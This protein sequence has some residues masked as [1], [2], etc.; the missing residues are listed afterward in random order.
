MSDRIR[1]GRWIWVGL[2]GLALLLAAPG[3][4]L[5]LW[6][7]NVPDDVRRSI[8]EA[9]SNHIGKL[10]DEKNEDGYRFRRASFSKA[11]RL[12][13]DGSYLVSVSEDT[14][15][16]E[17][18]KVERFEFTLNNDGGRWAITEKE[19]VDSWSGLFRSVL[20][21]EEFYEFDSIS[22]SREGLTVKGGK[23]Q[24][25]TD[26]FN[27]ELDSWVLEAENLQYEYQ[28]PAAL[29]A[30]KRAVWHVW[31]SLFQTI[32]DF[33]PERVFVS[34]H[35]DVCP[36][37]W[38]EMLTNPRPIERSQLDSKLENTFQKDHVK[39][40]EDR[41]KDNG[42]TGYR[43]PDRADRE[44]W[45]VS[46]KHK[47]DE[48][49]NFLR[50]NSA[51][52]H[53]VKAGI[54]GAVLFSYFSEA[55]RQ[56]DLS[57]AELERREEGFAKIVDVSSVIGEVEMSVQEVESVQGDLEIKLSVKEDRS[58]I[59]FFLSLSR[60]RGDAERDSRRPALTINKLEDGAGR[61]L[62]W[63]RTGRSGG[64]IILPEPIS[65]G[66]EVT[67]QI[68]Y[69]AQNMIYK[70]NPTYS[71]VPR[72]SWLP[73][74]TPSDLIETYE[75]TLGVPDKYKALGAGTMVSESVVDRKNVS[76]WKN[77]Y[78]LSFPTVIFGDYIHDKPKIKA[79]RADGTE[80][81]VNIYVDKTAASP[82]TSLNP[83]ITE[84]KVRQYRADIAG[85]R[86][87]VRPSQLRPLAEQ[88]VNALNLYGAL[89]GLDYPYGKLDLVNNPVQQGSGGQSPCAMVYLSSDSFRGEGELVAIH[90]GGTRFFKKL[91]AHEVGHQWWGGLFNNL[92]Q[93]NYWFIES[94]AEFS[95]ALWT[96]A[97]NSD[98][99]EK[100]EK[101]Y[102]EYM[103]Q[104]DGWRRTILRA[105]L[106]G[107]I[108]ESDMQAAPVETG[109]ARQALIYNK[110][111]YAF[112]MMRN[113]VGDEAMW[114]LM[115][116]IGQE[117]AGKLIVTSDL[118]RVAEESLGRPMGWF[119]DQWIRG[120]GIPQYKM[121]YE[122]QKAEDGNW[123]VRG[124]VEQRIVV[125]DGPTRSVVEGGKFLALVP[126]TV[127]GRDG[128][129]YTQ[130]VY[131][132]D[133]E[134]T[135][136]FKVPVE[137]VEVE[138]NKHGETLAHDVLVNRDWD[139]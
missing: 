7:D 124:S 81:P 53:E 119:F 52:I 90:G 130:P 91:V 47:G 116:D 39:A 131:V 134:A 136:G 55:T 137:P 5:A 104:V 97:V 102:K 68:A 44:T 62:T 9:L 36:E 41:L 74:I 67:I 73:F 132:R 21:D 79:T 70:L 37:L 19:L 69:D 20:G 32:R 3:L 48:L 18:I 117:F 103:E 115:K 50:Y 87:G 15:E 96:E 88:A 78:P 45:N 92:N 121:N 126:I 72:G 127:T 26:K 110:G 43:L 31:R 138:L 14:A 23:G 111:P 57:Q 6:E 10:A 49:W 63:V 80:I 86:F 56:S 17:Q 30:D 99:G 120:T 85:G 108:Q 133:S 59:P 109:S 139:S 106:T 11:F 34:C 40:T 58:T 28:P 66:S 100:P 46:V 95:S 114:K 118:Q 12:Q 65:A 4:S 2:I 75:I 112:H 98:G 13:D 54:G 125:G 123:V 33:T 105:G 107:N 83:P 8:T 122:T 93:Y 71:R 35:T 89:Y 113:L 29:G 84:A 24:L 61:P 25:F 82:I 76:V 128:Q 94:L 64:Q 129:E 1:F 22:F 77:Q 60:A 101:G 16:G 135:F 38:D 27:G 51:G 42:F